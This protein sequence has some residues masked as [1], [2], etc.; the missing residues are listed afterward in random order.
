MKMMQLTLKF[1]SLVIGPSFILRPVQEKLEAESQKHLII[2]QLNQLSALISIQH[3]PGKKG[4]G[5]ET[6]TDIQ[7]RTNR[8]ME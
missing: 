1:K 8:R 6:H 4:R 3:H 2:T 7:I 5:K